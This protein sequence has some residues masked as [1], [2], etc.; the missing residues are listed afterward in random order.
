MIDP[1]FEASKPGRAPSIVCAALPQ[2]A[3]TA[4]A[5]GGF[6]VGGAIPPAAV[7][8]PALDAAQLSELYYLLD[9]IGTPVKL[10]KG[11]Y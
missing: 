5:A 8:T 7:E 1:C 6:T 2:S 9:R 4:P 10:V 3:T 11:Q